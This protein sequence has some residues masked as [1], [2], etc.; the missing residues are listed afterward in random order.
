MYCLPSGV[1]QIPSSNPISAVGRM[2]VPGT[3]IHIG[4]V[5]GVLPVSKGACN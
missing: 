1:R 4:I 2:G 3:T 5:G